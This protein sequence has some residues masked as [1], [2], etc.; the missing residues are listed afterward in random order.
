MNIQLRF[1]RGPLA[2]IL[3]ALL[4]LVVVATYTAY[5]W[6][7]LVAW[8]ICGAVCYRVSVAPGFDRQV[9]P[10]E[11]HGIALAC[12]LLWPFVQLF[13]AATSWVNKPMASSK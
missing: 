9:S 1:D 4:A 13:L 2:W 7:C 3:L 12:V 8:V 10:N 6:W 5:G 11:R